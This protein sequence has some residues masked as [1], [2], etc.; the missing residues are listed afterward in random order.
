MQDPVTQVQVR[1]SPVLQARKDDDLPMAIHRLRRGEGLDAAWARAHVRNRVDGG[2]A[3]QQLRCEAHGGVGGVAL[4]P[5]V[6]HT[7]GCHDGV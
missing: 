1:L 7:Q 3:D 2:R 5:H 6:D 4:F